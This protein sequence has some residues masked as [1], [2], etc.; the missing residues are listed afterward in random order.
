MMMKRQYLAL[1]LTGLLILAGGGAAWAQSSN[2]RIIPPNAHPYGMTY[3]EWSADWW[4]WALAL[5]KD[6]NPLYDQEGNCSNG[7]NGQHGPVWFLVG[8]INESGAADRNC[9][10]PAGKA[11][12]FPI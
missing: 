12:F 11:L 2:P 7:A 3:G 8:V 9:T 5:P 6:Q 4:K 10:V 1:M